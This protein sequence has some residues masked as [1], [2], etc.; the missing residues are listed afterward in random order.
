[1]GQFYQ[2][3]GGRGI[4]ILKGWRLSTWLYSSLASLVRLHNSSLLRLSSE[5]LV[6]VEY[7][8]LRSGNGIK[9]S[10]RG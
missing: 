6:E 10:I 4:S 1:M 7:G 9:V 8:V 2:S 5:R 3:C